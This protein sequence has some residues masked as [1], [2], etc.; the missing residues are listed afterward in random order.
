M[1]Q[2]CGA[3]SRCINQQIYQLEFL[4]RR[5]IVVWISS[6]HNATVHRRRFVNKLSKNWLRLFALS[7]LT[8][9]CLKPTFKLNEIY[10][11]I[12]YQVREDEEC[13]ME[14]QHLS[15][16][17][18]IIHYYRYKLEKQKVLCPKIKIVLGPTILPQQKSN[19][20]HVSSNPPFSVG[21][22]VC[23]KILKHEK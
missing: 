20:V 1:Y 12:I 21:L 3:R 5:K 14:M 17:C 22:S 16:T 8:I 23:N 7:Y 19:W 11:G 10:I 6:K 4:Q 15:G 9:I 18:M 2:I 13:K